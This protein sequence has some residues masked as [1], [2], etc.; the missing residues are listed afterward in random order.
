MENDDLMI[1]VTGTSD[2]ATSALDKV[3]TKI[4][5]FQKRIEAATP[6]LTAFT[7]KM[8]SLAESSKAVSS[9][10][11]LTD[12]AN[13]QAVASKKAE[14]NMA[15]YQARL[16][17]SNLS[18]AKAKMQ[19]DKLSQSLQKVAETAKLDATNT[20]AFNMPINEFK[21]KYNKQATDANLTPETPED[22]YVPTPPAGSSKTASEI[23]NSRIPEASNVG[24]NIDTSVAQANLA[25]IEEFIN[26][27]TPAISNMSGEA[28][29]QFEA[30]AG[31]LRNVRMQIENQFGLYNKLN[32][33]AV[34]VAQS[35]GMESE[36][37]L[38]LEKQ[39]LS[40]DSAIGR[41]TSKQNSIKT[42][43]SRI[44]ASTDE[45]SASM[46]RFGSTSASATGKASNG[47]HK[48]NMRMFT[49]FTRIAAFKIYSAVAQG[50]QT[51]IQNIAQVSSKAN[52]AISALA[53]SSLY[54]KN[55]IASAL[56][57]AIQAL[58]PAI[59][60]LI[61]HLAALFNMIGMFFARLFG[62]ATT[63]TVAKT[64]NVNY[65]ASLDKTKNKANNATK[66]VKELQRSVLGFDELNR[67]SKESSPAGG[68]NGAGNNGGYSPPVPKEMFTT[69]KIPQDIL[70][71]ADKV[72]SILSKI[73][74]KLAPVENTIKDWWNNLTNAQKWGAGIGGTAGFVIGG[75]VGNLIAGPMGR[76]IGE[77]LGTVVGVVIGAWWAGLTKEEKWGAGIGA[78]AGAVIGGII[79]GIL[80]KGNPI[81]IAVGAALG[82]TI[83]AII[84]KWWSDLTTKEKWSAGIG[85]AA[86]ATV[87]GIIGGILTA[88]NPIGIAVGIALG[89]TIGA[90]VG[91]WWSDL[92][93]KQKWGAGIG[94]GAGAVIGGIIGNLICPGIG[95]A[96][97]ALLG[98]TIGTIIGKWW[99]TLKSSQKWSVG[100]TGIGAI[101][102]AIIGTIFLGPLGTVLGAAV[103]GLV[104][105]LI[106]NFWD[107]MKSP[108]HWKVGATGIGAVI[109]GIIGT[110]I[111]GPLG[112]IIGA[113]LGGAVGYGIGKIASHAKGTSHHLGGPAL[114]NDAP[115]AVY[116]EMV[117][118][119][120]GKTFIPNDRNVLIPDLPTGSEVLSAED[121]KALIPHYA[122][123]IG[124]TDFG[125]S[126]GG[127]SEAVLSRMDNISKR[128]ENL[129]KAILERPV[130]I[131]ADDRKLA[132][133]VNRGNK[134]ISRRYNPIASS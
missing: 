73:K 4:S 117:Q 111:G 70:K 103:G 13:T 127:S 27:L 96:V 75:I 108:S 80:T 52:S 39:M 105:N 122:E 18:M 50:L 33:S 104:A 106:K 11:K 89:G 64:A 5:E 31:K 109:G 57:P 34:S 35:T 128:M 20:A 82:G 48:F 10:K 59:T 15:M 113:A 38:K 118:L 101:V 22:T 19:A 63:V 125:S 43:M 90:I 56:M 58:T 32:Q 66:A 120:T 99:S 47:L 46:K 21:Q 116:R 44:A 67:L 129:E 14:A 9:L 53:T 121:T 79:G 131:Y 95:A 76:R 24:I 16:D 112:T 25:K 45:A 77:L 40:A 107:Y 133:S 49:M 42:E 71:M 98:G 126:S 119:P 74:T 23:L 81:G 36:A 7:K 69:K 87:G 91:K 85:A 60:N 54:L 93:I 132:E 1:E 134:S 51:G 2:K 12:T 6:A 102:G 41:L 30:L 92:T 28:Q 68:S 110:I 83:G 55:S 88:G 86:G 26:R 123:G 3:I 72:K 65:A 97:G 130:K 124:H 62:G 100:T 115:G 37:Y 84:G 17:R 29:A 78:G 61:N 114:V 8:D 94:A